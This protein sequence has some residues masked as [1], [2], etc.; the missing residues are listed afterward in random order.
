MEVLSRWLADLI[1][2]IG[3]Q[4]HSF[5]D[6]LLILNFSWLQ[7]GLDIAL[8]A[9]VFYL[10]FKQLKGTRTVHMLIGLLVLVLFF[11]ISKALQLITFGWLLE[12]AFT[13]LLV[14]IPVLFQ[15]ELR[16]AL[17]KLGHTKPFLKQ[18]AK[19]LD[20]MIGDIVESCFALAKKREGALVVIQQA[21]PLKEYIE[22]GTPLNADISKELILSIFNHQTPLH[23]GAVIMVDRKIV[24]ASCLLPHTFNVDETGVGT[25]HK[26][27]I[28][29]S[30]NTD[31]LIIVVSEER[32]TISFANQGAIE[33]N[34]LPARLHFLL[35]QHLKP[36]KPKHKA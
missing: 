11:W 14:A 16:S 35:T 4:V 24:A 15:P 8:V 23:D 21:V 10:I 32:G 9:I 29:L 3:R 31:A 1:I 17:E 19:D 22:T 18:Q 7:I 12:K 2:F 34:I 20:K 36:H 28:G 13:V 26:A 25:R 27:A 30:Q 5:W 6:N 33:K